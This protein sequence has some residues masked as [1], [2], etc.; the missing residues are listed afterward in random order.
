MFLRFEPDK[1]SSCYNIQELPA[2]VKMLTN[3]FRISR[4]KLSDIC[5]YGFFFS[6]KCQY[7]KEVGRDRIV[8]SI[9]ET[10]PFI[11]SGDCKQAA[12]VLLVKKIFNP[13]V[14]HHCDACQSWKRGNTPPCLE[15]G[16]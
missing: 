14:E 6:P 15:L 8:W 3:F 12:R 7:L 11:G 1:Q 4:R 2:I 5:R 10:E 13:H 16:K 9:G